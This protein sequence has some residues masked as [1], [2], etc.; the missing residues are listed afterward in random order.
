MT[1]IVKECLSTQSCFVQ[2]ARVW[3]IPLSLQVFSNIILNHKLTN[4]MYTVQNVID[5]GK[6]N[7]TPNFLDVKYAEFVFSKTEE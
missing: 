3:Q 7:A 5:I 2:M 1:N 6:I 4:Y